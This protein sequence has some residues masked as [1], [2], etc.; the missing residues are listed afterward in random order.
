MR[1]TFPR[2]SRVSPSGFTLVEIMVV[3]VIIG[4]LASLAIPAFKRV[5]RSAQNARAINDFRIFA[6][7]FEV[8][9]SQNGGWPPNAGAG[10]VPTGVNKD[11]KEDTWKAAATVIGGRWNWDLDRA[12]FKAGVSISGV[13][14]TD[15]QL[16][17]IDT[18]LDDGNLTTGLFQKIADSP[19]RVSYILE[20]N[21]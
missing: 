8:Y 16:I 14:V 18:K 10:V 4:L 6:Q 15:E 19:A 5:Q 3:V 17:E 7:A 13:T 2:S 20:Q 9:N 12:E 21:P 11:F 1:S